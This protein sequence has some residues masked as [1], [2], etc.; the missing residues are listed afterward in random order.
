MAPSPATHRLIIVVAA[1]CLAHRSNHGHPH[2]NPDHIHDRRTASHHQPLSLSH[3]HTCH[4]LAL[5]TSRSLA[6]APLAASQHAIKHAHLDARRLDLGLR[7]CQA[8]CCRHSCCSAIDPHWRSA[9]CVRVLELGRRHDLRRARAADRHCVQDA[10][11]HA[12]ERHRLVGRSHQVPQRRW[13][14]DL[15]AASRLSLC[16]RAVDQWSQGHGRVVQGRLSST[17]SLL[18][19]IIIIMVTVVDIY[20]LIS[21]GNLHPHLTRIKPPSICI[22]LSIKDPSRR[23]SCSIIYTALAYT[24]SLE[25]SSTANC[26]N[27]SHSWSAR[28]LLELSE[29]RSSTVVQP[30]AAPPTTSTCVSL[31]MKIT[32]LGSCS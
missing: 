1:R 32:L 18:D 23:R 21:R 31:P 20:H 8:R 19:G 2:H 28:P 25:R 30:M 26:S 9:G 24:H 5:T 11:H 10:G 22:Y 4:A 6:R 16:A 17:R 3:A 7:C 13:R 27:E 12:P 14:L 15:A 29:P